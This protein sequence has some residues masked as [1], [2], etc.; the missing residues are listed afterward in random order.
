MAADV[1]TMIEIMERTNRFKVKSQT[2]KRFSLRLSN[3]IFQLLL[4]F[5]N[6]RA[7]AALFG[8]GDGEAGDVRMVAQEICNRAAERA[9]AVT[10]DDADARKA[11]Q[12]SFI[13]KF[14]NGGDGFVRCAAHQIPLGIRF[15]LRLGQGHLRRSRMSR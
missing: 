11:V 4:Q 8:R 1:S 15:A 3:V 12:E 13:E 10:V 6:G 7:C 5:Y 2:S 9:R 14:I